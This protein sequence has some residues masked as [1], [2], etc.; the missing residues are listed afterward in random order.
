MP[1]SAPTGFIAHAADDGTRCALGRVFTIRVPVEMQRH[2]NL[3]RYRSRPPTSPGSNA[4]AYPDNSVPNWRFV[5]DGLPAWTA[6]PAGQ[7]V[8]SRSLGVIRT[9]A[10]F[11][12]LARSGR[13][14][15][16]SGTAGHRR[17]L[18]WDA[19]GRG[20]RLRS[21]SSCTTRRGHAYVPART[22]GVSVQR[23]HE[24]GGP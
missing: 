15:R 9:M 17:A 6:E 18:L 23:A 21:H 13:H 24:F 22:S 1:L 19:G 16:S 4:C 3:V 11:H 14:T 12:L 5:Y 8:R 20:P 2:R 10:G 7:N